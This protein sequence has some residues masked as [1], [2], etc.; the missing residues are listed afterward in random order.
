MNP[1]LRLFCLT[2]L[3][4]IGLSSESVARSL[5]D[6]YSSVDGYFLAIGNK[7]YL[8]TLHSKQQLQEFKQICADKGSFWA[9]GSKAPVT[10]I[11]M[12]YIKEGGDGPL[13]ELSLKGDIKK[14]PNRSAILYS[15]TPFPEPEWTQRK[16]EK[17]EIEG[18]L[19]VTPLGK[20]QYSAALKNARRGK[21]SIIETKQHDVIYLIPWRITNDGVV[22]E[23]DFLIIS[24]SQKDTQG[25]YRFKEARG[26]VIGIAD[27]DRDGMPDLQISMF[28]DGI[29]ES[30]KSV[31]NNRLQIFISSH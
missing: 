31:V 29:C 4:T 23:Q 2:T 22:D 28:C 17:S 15:T 8:S 30:V 19:P 12:R 7:A 16:A 9:L 11:K 21:A 18:L 26:T 27:I 5:P 10:C 1:R 14:D 3:L 25:Q 20:K 24:K 6:S 13:Y